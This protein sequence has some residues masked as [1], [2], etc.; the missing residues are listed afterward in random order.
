MSLTNLLNHDSYDYL[1]GMIMTGENHSSHSIIL[2]MVQDTHLP[3][4]PPVYNKNGGKVDWEP[5]LVG[6]VLSQPACAGTS[7]AFRRDVSPSLSFTPRCNGENWQF[8]KSVNYATPAL[9]ENRDHRSRL[10]I[11]K[12]DCHVVSAQNSCHC[13]TRQPQEITAQRTCK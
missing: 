2:I 11:I 10:Q 4:I 6:L 7:P 5:A 13:K 9:Q 1:I 3:S 12:A 8:M